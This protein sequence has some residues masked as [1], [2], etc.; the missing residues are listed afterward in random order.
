MKLTL[1]NLLIRFRQDVVFLV[2]LLSFKVLDSLGTE[3][4]LQVGFTE[5]NFFPAWL[6]QQVGNI[7]THI[8]CNLALISLC[9]AVLS[10]M[11][12]KKTRWIIWSIS[13]VL[14]GLADFGHLIMWRLHSEGYLTP[15]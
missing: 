7:W 2:F 12:D 9:I 11:G 3:R 10:L 13:I 5:K 8:I 4:L 14:I 15:F 1:N 6:G